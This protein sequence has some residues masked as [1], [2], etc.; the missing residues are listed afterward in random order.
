MFVG[1]GAQSWALLV[2][3]VCAGLNAGMAVALV[4]VP[5]AV[6]LGVP[7]RRAVFWALGGVALALASNV[8]RV[9]GLL[10]ATERLGTATAL[11][12]VHPA[13]GAVLLT[14]VFLLMWLRAPV[15][16]T[17]VTAWSGRQVRRVG[18]AVAAVSPGALAAIAVLAVL[19]G[20]ESV[21]LEAFAPL[22]PVG[23]PGGTV[24]TP[25]DYVRLPAGWNVEAQGEQ[26]Y[27]NLFGRE[28]DSRWL[29]L[30][31]T[32]GAAV[33]AQLITTPDRGRL[34]AYDPEACRLFHGGD[35]VG[36]RTIALDG[37]GVA[38]LIDTSDRRRGVEGASRRPRQSLIYW[39]APFSLQGREMHARVTLIAQEAD[40]ETLPPPASYGLA[41]GG[42]LFDRAD[43]TLVALARGIT[44]EVL[45]ATAAT[46]QTASAGARPSA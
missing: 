18:G 22:P 27:Q 29:L 38:T 46:A 30:R 34:R 39:E 23:P 28:S 3:D 26:A 25:L 5:G 41:P 37:G 1:T 19:F 35:V 33:M 31:S 21:R 6:Q 9:A 4:S 44:R 2:G 20:R 8:L 24:A 7:W 10:V 43:S 12:T 16:V 36:R 13:L 32:E 45:A 14:G 42:V 11:G 17:A 40:E 15:A